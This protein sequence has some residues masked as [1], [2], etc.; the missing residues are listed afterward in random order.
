MIA[1]NCQIFDAN[2]HALSF[3][4]VANRINSQGEGKPIVIQD[5]VWICANSVVLP[6][7]T[8]GEGSVVSVNSVVAVDIPPMSLA[9]GNPATVVKRF[10]QGTPGRR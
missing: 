2:G 4:D 8:I 3:E 1:A 10:P 6:G 7:V 9:R 5:N